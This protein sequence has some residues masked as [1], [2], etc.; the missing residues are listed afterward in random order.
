M[1]CLN[2]RESS[3]L[4]CQDSRLQEGH[5]HKSSYMLLP[6]QRQD[7]LDLACPLQLSLSASCR[8]V[9]VQ[10]KHRQ[11]QCLCLIVWSRLLR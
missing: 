3:P 8:P 10:A 5:D 6:H 7:L 9:P 4:V 11:V 2:R 1:R